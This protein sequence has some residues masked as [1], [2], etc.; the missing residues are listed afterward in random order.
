[1]AETVWCFATGLPV[2]SRGE[3][4]DAVLRILADG[5]KDSAASALLSLSA[6]LSGTAPALEDDDLQLA[7]FLLYALAY[8]SLEQAGDDLEWDPDLIAVRRRLEAR[9]E[10]DLRRRVGAPPRPEPVARDVARALFTMTA[11]DDGPSLT[12]FVARRAT[13][14]QLRELLILRSIYTLRE[15]DPHS[16]A[17]PRLTGQAKAAL[18]E[19]QADEYGGGQLHRMHSQLFADA[20][21]GAGLSDEYGAWTW[22]PP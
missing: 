1:M 12:H 14:G 15:A 11:D 9:H 22:F 8:G 18:I 5:R 16:W 19:I 13:A 4:S 3:L 7:L 6:D 2:T 17:I 20:M 10:A 21:R